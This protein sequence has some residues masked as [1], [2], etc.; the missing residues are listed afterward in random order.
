[1]TGNMEEGSLFAGSWYKPK[2]YFHGDAYLPGVQ[3]SIQK[4]YR[5]CPM[6]GIALADPVSGRDLARYQTSP[7]IGEV[8]SPQPVNPPVYQV[9]QYTTAPTYYPAPPPVVVN[10]HNTSGCTIVLA[11][12]GAIVLIAFTVACGIPFLLA[13]I[14]STVH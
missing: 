11:V 5:I 6:C 9:P 1:M 7:A 12:L 13:L 10:N 8:I 2:G 14:G 3:A 4:T